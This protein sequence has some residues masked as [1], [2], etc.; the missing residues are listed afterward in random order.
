LETRVEEVETGLRSFR[1]EFDRRITPL[2][3]WIGA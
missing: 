2:E 3:R 1:S